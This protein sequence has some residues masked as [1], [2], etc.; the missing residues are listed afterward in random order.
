MSER[1]ST[2][3]HGQTTLVPRQRAG[4]KRSVT[5]C[6]TC[7]MQLIFSYTTDRVRHKKCDEAPGACNNCTSTGRRCDGYDQH[8][9][10][11]ASKANTPPQAKF[12]IVPGLVGGV[13]R[14]M[15]REE[16]RC[17]SF[18]QLRTMPAMVGF[19]DSALW[20]QLILQMGHEEPAVYHA[21][22]ALSAFH[23]DSER[24]GM[25]LSKEDLGNTWHRFALEQSMR[26]FSLLHTR[27]ASHDPRLREV[28]L[29]CCLVFVLLEWL[30]G[31][32]DKAFEHLRSGIRMLKEFGV[33]MTD[34]SRVR[35]LPVERDLVAAFAHLDIQ[36][37]QFGETSSFIKGNSMQE[38]TT[39]QSGGT[40]TFRN[41]SDARE[42]L[43]HILEPVFNFTNSTQALSHEQVAIQYKSL[44]REQIRRCAEVSEFART[45]DH[46]RATR[47]YKLSAK[48]QRS[49]DVIHLH[50]IAASLNLETCLL[51][52]SHPLLDNYTPRFER[53]L[54]RVEEVTDKFPD[55]PSVCMDMGI[56]PP[57]FFVATGCWNFR[58]RERAIEALRSWPH[59][60]GPWDSNLGAR[61]ATE[62]MKLES[63]AGSAPPSGDT[64][65]VT[66]EPANNTPS[67]RG[68][69]VTISEDQ[70]HARLSYYMGNERNEWRFKLDGK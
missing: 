69:S 61:I 48:E 4:G 58:V 25:P 51:D 63:T 15:N 23:Q 9:L 30:R 37:A 49:A 2:S 54:A 36:S 33:K 60:E 29:L 13:H 11:R 32:Y 41:I 16:Q 31:Q 39:L 68:V 28:T 27:R 66:G 42:A 52:S 22:V 17:F 1:I 7:R 57:L 35:A 59:R 5:G 53:L 8:R 12:Q 47:Y 3:G 34:E 70:I 62:I 40:P 10:P 26:S 56:I 64:E 19:F 43:N 20:Q 14:T 6:R 46:F 55:R 65:G 44:Y 24:Q 38:I 21:I 67:P 50:Q 45:F 18:F